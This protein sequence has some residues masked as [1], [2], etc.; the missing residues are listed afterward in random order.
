MTTPINRPLTE[1]ER[2]LLCQLAIEVVAHQTGRDREQVADELD[3]ME[4]EVQGD[5]IDVYLKANGNVLVHATRE[6]LA[7]HANNPNEPMHGQSIDPQS[8]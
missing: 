4:L 8:P 7:F 3:T 1:Q 6:W 2:D 5:A